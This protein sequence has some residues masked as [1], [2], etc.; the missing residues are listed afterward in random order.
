VVLGQVE[1]A[2]SHYQQAL[3]HCPP[4]DLRE[5]SSILFNHAFLIAQQ[6]DIDQALRLYNQSLQIDEQ[7]NDV[8][9]KSASLHQMAGILAQQ[10]DIDQA[11]RLYNQSLQIKEQINDVKGKAATLNNMAYCAGEMGDRPRQLELNLQ[12][13]QALGQ[14]RAYVDLFTVLSNLGGTAETNSQRYPA[15]AVW[16]LLR[17]QAPLLDA[18]I[19]VKALYEAVPQGD[20]LEALLATFACV[21]CAQRGQEHPQIEQ[22]QELGMQMLAGAAA[23]QGIETQAAFE[24]W[25]TQNK[26]NDP[27]VVLPRL[28]QCLEALIADTW[29]FDP[30]P[31]IAISDR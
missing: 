15:Q 19:A 21:L 28:N 2:N 25:F 6:G 10:G 16:L 27:D 9:G 3:L 24:T 30:T 7:I 29:A 11:L 18:M 5:Q 17:I 4:D 20:D 26:L 8:K 13:A 12:A 14:V 23:A 1:S 31:L 22:L